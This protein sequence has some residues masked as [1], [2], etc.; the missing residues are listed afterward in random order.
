MIV[1]GVKKVHDSEFLVFRTFGITGRPK[2]KFFKLFCKLKVS[3][4]VFGIA[5]S[6]FCG[7]RKTAKIPNLP[8]NSGRIYFSCFFGKFGLNNGFRGCW[9]RIVR[10]PIDPDYGK[11]NN[12]ENTEFT[13]KFRKNLIFCFSVNSVSIYVFRIAD[14]KFRGFRLILIMVFRK[15]AKIPNLPG[16][17]GEFFFAFL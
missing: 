17:S 2:F 15:Y 3:L 14:T 8:G 11:P 9:F 1:S 7:F 13:G 10:F 12:H 6:E 5:Y 4:K 16:Y